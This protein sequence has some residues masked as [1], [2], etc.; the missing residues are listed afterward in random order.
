MPEETAERQCMV[1]RNTFTYNAKFFLKRGFSPPKRCPEHA[2]KHRDRT[3]R[4]KKRCLLQ[5]GVVQLDIPDSFVA[6]KVYMN[7]KDHGVEY[8]TCSK[9]K[10]RPSGCTRGTYFTVYD[11]RNKD[12]NNLVP[13]SGDGARASLRI[14]LAPQ[15]YEYLVLDVSE[16]GEVDGVLVATLDTQ[17]PRG[18][19]TL[20]HE[21]GYSTDIGNSGYKWM[22]KVVSS[23]DSLG[24]KLCQLLQKGT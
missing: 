22:L 17:M 14:M 21:Q 11:H 4:G 13:L 8:I 23:E 19:I 15:G 1:C 7:R 12:V 9:F 16:N 5:L 24:D 6:D 20:W 3:S 18:K 10:I 2:A